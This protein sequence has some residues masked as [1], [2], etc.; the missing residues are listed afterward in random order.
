MR[1]HAPGRDVQ[2]VGAGL[3]RPPRDLQTVLERVAGRLPEAD[4]VVVVDRAE[5]HAQEV[6]GVQ[7]RHVMATAD[8]VE[9]LIRSH[10]YGDEARFCT[11]ARRTVA[12]AAR[13][14]GQGAAA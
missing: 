10:A 8:Q 4:G 5:L 12:R 13:S 3:L 11:N 7:S 1:E 2:R 9:A 6:L 14:N